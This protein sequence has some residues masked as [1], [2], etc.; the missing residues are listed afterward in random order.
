MSFM[1]LLLAL[2][3]EE[4]ITPSGLPPSPSAT[5]IRFSVDDSFRDWIVPRKS[6]WFFGGT[7]P[8]AQI[9]RNMA[10]IPHVS[11]MD[12]SVGEL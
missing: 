10:R 12:E 11:K 7:T 1:L 4:G 5:K 6:V 3:S 8:A 9:E 2:V